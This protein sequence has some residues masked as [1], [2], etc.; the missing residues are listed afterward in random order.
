MDFFAR[1]C[2]Y[3]TMKNIYILRQCGAIAQRNMEVYGDKGEEQRE[4]QGEWGR[5]RRRSR[6]RTSRMI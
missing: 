6:R 5:T 4:E 3:L 2:L 1:F